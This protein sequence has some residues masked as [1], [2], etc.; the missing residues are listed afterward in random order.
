[1]IEKKIKKELEASLGEKKVF[2]EKE[3]LIAYS[4]DATGN[5]FLP[6]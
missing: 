6:G 4:Y 5:E 3:F 2:E 1:M